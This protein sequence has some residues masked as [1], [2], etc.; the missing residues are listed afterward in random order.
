LEDLDTT[1]AC[2]SDLQCI[3]MDNQ[4]ATPMGSSVLDKFDSEQPHCGVDNLDTTQ[5]YDQDLKSGSMGHRVME[6]PICTA[7]LEKTDSAD[8]LPTLQETVEPPMAPI[9]ED[10][11][12]STPR[13]CL[14]DIP[15]SSPQELLEAAQIRTALELLEAAPIRGAQ[16][17]LEAAST[18]AASAVSSAVSKLTGDIPRVSPQ[19][20]TSK[21]GGSIDLA[22]A[23]SPTGLAQGGSIDWGMANPV[24]QGGSIDM[25]MGSMGNSMPPGGGSSGSADLPVA[26]SLPQ[27]GSISGSIDF[28]VANSLPQGVVQMQGFSV[29][30]PNTDGRQMLSSARTVQDRNCRPWEAAKSASFPN[31]QRCQTGSV[32]TFCI[33]SETPPCPGSGSGGVKPMCFNM[34]P[35]VRDA[36]LLFERHKRNTPGA[37]S[38]RAVVRSNM[39][40]GGMGGR[41]G[42][43]SAPLCRLTESHTNS[44]SIV[45]DSGKK[46]RLTESRAAS[47]NIALDFGKNARNSNMSCERTGSAMLETRAI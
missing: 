26:N 25:S 12:L 13:K 1:Q 16:E 3:S 37:V 14:E 18:R 15:S 34:S 35:R 27:G 4:L 39:L 6:I 20:A 32:V 23:N 46:G 5:A 41:I 38:H 36:V 9:M 44:D 8:P 10:R 42:S 28:A 19:Q 31:V 29:R 30:H 7:V 22:V 43:S 11:V 21:T 24:P 17:L 2:D 45:L 47:G 33:G 40:F